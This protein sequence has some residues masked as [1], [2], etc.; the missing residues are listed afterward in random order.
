MYLDL[1]WRSEANEDK[2]YNTRD[3]VQI[4]A[5]ETTTTLAAVQKVM[6]L[7]GTIPRQR[8]T[9]THGQRSS[10]HPGS[11]PRQRQTETF[12]NR[13]IG[14]STTDTVRRT[15]VYDNGH[16]HKYANQYYS[17]PA[18]TG[19]LHSTKYTRDQTPS[20]DQTAPDRA[21]R[22]PRSDTRKGSHSIPRLTHIHIPFIPPHL[23]T[24]HV[25]RNCENR[26]WV[27]PSRKRNF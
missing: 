11:I 24:M 14:D 23:S 20:K 9:E 7:P 8:Q 17:L 1:T 3:W 4:I 16:K 25:D 22:G 12:G 18:K 27:T 21:S 19:H 26:P 15:T 6:S 5:D 10:P 2:F 13:T